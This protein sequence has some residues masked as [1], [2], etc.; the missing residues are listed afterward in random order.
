M[1]NSKKK[2]AVTFI[3]EESLVPSSGWEE[4]DNAKHQVSS[5]RRTF[6]NIRGYQETGATGFK[7]YLFSQKSVV[8]RLVSSLLP[9]CGKFKRIAVDPQGRRS[10][11]LATDY[12]DIP[13]RCYC[14]KQSPI[15][16]S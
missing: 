15:T 7:N 9:P 6:K 14:V 3:D 16:G 12:S 10:A 8:V 11:W 2:S 5:L 1:R 4:F 13:S